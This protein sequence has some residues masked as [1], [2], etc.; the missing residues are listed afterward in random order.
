MDAGFDSKVFRRQ[1]KGI[2]AHRMEYIIALHP[3]HTAPAV[4]Q[5][6]IPPMSH[7]ELAGGGIREHFEQIDFRLIRRNVKMIQTGI[8][9]FLLPFPIDCLRIS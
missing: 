9:P 1:T 3:L 6:V 7:V 5:T 4:G 2:K 8:C